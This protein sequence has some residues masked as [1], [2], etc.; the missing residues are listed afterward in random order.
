MGESLFVIDAYAHIYQ[1][2]YAIRGLTG[3]DGEPVNAVYGF[4]RMIENLR[5]AYEPDYMAVAFDVPGELLRNEIYDQY[6]ANR[7]PMPA[8]LQRQIPLIR[9]FLEAQRIPQVSVPGYEADDVLAALAKRAA[10][11]GINTVIVTTDKDAEQLIDEHVRVLHI[12]KD[13]E[14]LLGP[15]ELKEHKGLEPRQVVDMLSLAGDSTDNIPGVPGIGPKTALRLI[16]QFGSVENLYAN[17]NKVKSAKLREKLEAHRGDVELAGEL[18]VLRSDIPLEVSMEE[19]R[20]G[21]LDPAAL[22]RFYRALGFRSLMREGAPASTDER[23]QASLLAP[24]REAPEPDTLETLDKHYTTVT[25]LAALAELVGTLSQQDVV[26]LDL[27]TTSLQPRKARIV[28]FAFSWQ[29]H[30]GVYVV[31]DGADAAFICYGLPAGATVWTPWRC[32]T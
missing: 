21:R 25:S 11:Q 31:V 15:Q 18:V 7:S 30:Q 1:F 23:R 27:E 8:D 22:D 16:Q 24:E 20:T 28:G 12:R 29:P 13:E 9:D 6:K 10:E 17:L 19:C 26:S 2:F 3:P 4:A 32:A 5:R 14:E